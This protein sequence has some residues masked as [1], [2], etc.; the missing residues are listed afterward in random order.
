MTQ[1]HNLSDLSSLLIEYNVM[2]QK[3]TVAFAE[4]A[5]IFTLVKHF[6]TEKN[7]EEALHIVGLAL[8]QFPDSAEMFALKASLLIQIEQDDLA[9][10]YID[11][12]LL[13]ACNDT[14]LLLI[15]AE[16]LVRNELFEEAEELL[17]ILK[18]IASVREKEMVYLL[19]ARMYELVDDYGEMFDALAAVLRINPKNQDALTRIWLATELSGRYEESIK[20]HIAITDEEPYAHLAWHNLGHAYLG[21]EDYENATDAY[22]F[23]IVSNEEFEFAYRDCGAAYIQTRNFKQALELY[24]EV[25]D[26]FTADY[27]VLLK[28]GYCNQRLGQHTAA[29]LYYK[30]SIETQN[31]NPEAFF[32]LGECMALQGDLTSAVLAFSRAI[33]QDDSYEE[34]FYALA[35]VYGIMGEKE[36]AAQAFCRAN[37][38]APE[39]TEYWIGHAKFYRAQDCL[40]EALEIIEEAE[41]NIGGADILYS[42]IICLFEM[43]RRKEA[44]LCLQDALCENFNLHKMLF[45]ELPHLENDREVLS[46][47]SLCQENF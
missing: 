47:I 41:M 8:D 23:A 21:V 9:L 42:R 30:R 35:Q 37:E 17:C 44:M 45:D 20:L 36:K 16:I 43:G 40:T 29:V 24:R 25:E 34:F 39:N 6:R 2:S 4:K 38:I 18:D 31:H 15:K 26:R 27:D 14:Q 46:L 19:E 28:I 7:F 5:V 1:L 22:E 3:G 32:R 13:F 33:E 10:H 12:A 11:T